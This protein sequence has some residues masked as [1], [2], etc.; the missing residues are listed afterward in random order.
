METKKAAA[1]AESAGLQLY[2]GTMI[3]TTLG[4]AAAAHIYA[5]MPTFAFDTELVGPLL[6]QEQISFNTIKYENFQFRIPEGPGLGIEIDEN[7][8]IHYSRKIHL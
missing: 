5:T 3:D 2:G 7:K 6:Y 4:T 1:I 8:I